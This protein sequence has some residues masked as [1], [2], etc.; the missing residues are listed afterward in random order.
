MS[1]A[2]DYLAS[3]GK[4]GQD[5]A[6]GTQMERLDWLHGHEFDHLDFVSFSRQVKGRHRI[7]GHLSEEDA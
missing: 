1:S 3:C 2:V 6:F 4:C 7:D 5:F